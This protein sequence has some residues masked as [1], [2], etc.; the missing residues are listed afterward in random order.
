MIKWVFTIYS[1]FFHP[2]FH[3]IHQP[4]KDGFLPRCRRKRDV[5]V[6]RYFVSYEQLFTKDGVHLR[7][8][9]R[10]YPVFTG[11][12]QKADKF[13]HKSVHNCE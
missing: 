13:V 9:S 7:C 2:L 4:K 10:I 8:T 6:F 1:L 11:F 5:T 12:F 3:I